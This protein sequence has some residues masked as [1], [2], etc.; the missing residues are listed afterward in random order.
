[1]AARPK[2]FGLT[3]ELE[4]K[5]R[6]EYDSGLAKKVCT[7]FNEVCKGGSES[8]YAVDFGNDFSWEGTHAKLKDGKLIIAVANRICPEKKKKIQTLN[9]PFKLMENTGNFL[10]IAQEIGVSATDLF[11]TASLYE[12]K[13][14]LQ[15]CICNFHWVKNQT[16]TKPCL[17]TEI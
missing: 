7:W 10:A 9:S 14:I 4:N 17:R 6:G 5:K 3:R 8:Q 16:V 15:Y 1:M 12:G 2:G 11:Q 13:L